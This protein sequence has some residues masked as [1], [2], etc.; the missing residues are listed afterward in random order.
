MLQQTCRKC[1]NEK[2]EEYLPSELCDS[3]LVSEYEKVKNNSETEESKY[4]Q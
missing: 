2:E 1:F 4:L 3:H